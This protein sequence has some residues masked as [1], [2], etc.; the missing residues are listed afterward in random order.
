MSANDEEDSPNTPQTSQVPNSI[1]SSPPPSFRSR[2]SSITSQHILAEDPLISDAD[3]TLADTFDDGSDS[4][5]DMVDHGDDRQRIMR[6]NP[7]QSDEE[8]N[9]SVAGL[10]P[11]NTQF[12]GPTPAA[13]DESNRVH[14]AATN[15]RFSSA[16]D[17]VFANLNAKPERGEK[18]EEQPPVGPPNFS[19]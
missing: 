1:P 4:D 3:R 19:F 10:Q 15:N 17:G 5:N 2:A 11:A 7:S 6:G 9:T 16:N 12:P 13:L 18:I 14:S 8:R